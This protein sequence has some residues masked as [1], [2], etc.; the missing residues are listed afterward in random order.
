MSDQQ[1]RQVRITAGGVSKVASLAET[2]TARAV[3][4]ALP[5]DGRVNRWGDEIYFSIPV[6]LDEEPGSREEVAVGDV[7][8][9]PPGS[10][11]CIFWGRTPASHAN[12]PRAASR[13]NV[14]GHIAEGAD[15]L[16]S[17]K[18]GERVRVERAE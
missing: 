1:K 2:A 17:V 11:L 4:D 18:S 13:V 10:A 9:W 3:W 5:F 7:A 16:G 12:E 14:F 6:D 15:E 8:Y